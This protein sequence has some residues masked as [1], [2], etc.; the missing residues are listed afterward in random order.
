[1]F[2]T[3]QADLATVVLAPS[4]WTGA[5]DAERALTR[6][7]AP[8]RASPEGRWLVRGA[9]RFAV[10][11]LLLRG[12]RTDEPLAAVTPFDTDAPARLAMAA[13]AWRILRGAPERLD[14]QLTAQRR[15]RLS[16]CLRALDARASGASHREI[17]AA[18][19]GAHRL[20]DLPWN[21]SALRDT[22]LRLARDGEAL[23]AGGYRRLLRPSRISR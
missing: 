15:R 11:L 12:A 20:A 8:G 7:A 16:L 23:V 13:R 1:M 21:S 4:L 3:T 22:T 17:A 9:G 2:W 5:S 18:L 14:D 19:F 10:H 6:R